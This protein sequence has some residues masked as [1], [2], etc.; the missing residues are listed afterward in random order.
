MHMTLI[1][2]ASAGSVAPTIRALSA[3][4]TA[5]TGIGIEVRH[6]PA[7]LLAHSISQGIATD[8]FISA[9]PSGPLW[10]HQSGSFEQPVTLA[11][12]RMCVVARPGVKLDAVDPLPTLADER[13]RIA[14]S[15][16][17]ADP[18]GDYAQAFFDRLAEREPERAANILRRT[19]S[20]YGGVMP[21]LG[22]PQF[23]PV[24]RVLTNGEADLAL[25]YASGI[26]ALRAQLPGLGSCA[27]PEALSPL[28]TISACCRAL[29][30]TA[31]RALLAFL[32][33]GLAQEEYVARGFILPIARTV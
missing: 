31:V 32:Q 17:G 1:N 22:L 19:Q 28:T 33:S 26:A 16:P 8:L 21:A 15:T 23:N 9:S 13:W 5:D 27:L 7:G 30:T 10:L 24:L 18:G 14:M 3:R 25:I 20:M 2:V 4:F 12:N 11:H 29:S 6:G